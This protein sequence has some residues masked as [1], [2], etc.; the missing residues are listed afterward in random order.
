MLQPHSSPTHAS[1][2]THSDQWSAAST[3]LP[4]CSLLQQL[5]HLALLSLDITIK[6]HTIN[7]GR[8]T[9]TL[10]TQ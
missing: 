6:R 3:R 7:R 5:P 4:T 1:H 8:T 10:H 2:T 9:H